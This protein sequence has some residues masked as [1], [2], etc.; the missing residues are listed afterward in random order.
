M[1]AV[2]DPLLV[3]VTALAVVEAG[4]VAAG[5]QTPP[6]QLHR[7]LLGVLLREAVHDP[8]NMRH[9]WTQSPKHAS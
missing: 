1:N 6:L 7:H 2:V 3:H 4:V 8:Y 9:G 5:A